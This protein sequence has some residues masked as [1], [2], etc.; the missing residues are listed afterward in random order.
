MTQLLIRHA[1]AGDPAA[2]TG[3]DRERPLDDEGRSQAAA[4][5]ALLEPYPLERVLTSPYLRCVQT[6][7]PLAVARKLPLEY[8]HELGDDARPEDALA[9]IG[10]LEA[11]GTRAA[12][13][14]HGDLIR[15]L[16]GEELAKGEVAVVDATTTGLIVRQRLSPPELELRARGRPF[17]ANELVREGADD[18]TGERSQEVDPEV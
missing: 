9:L 4:L 6:V 12:L 17:V 2:W 1:T 16:L 7:E 15:E 5:V 13:C 3:D 10:H 8:R 14:T 11:A 18:R